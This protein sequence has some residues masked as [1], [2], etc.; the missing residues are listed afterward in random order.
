MNTPHE[1]MSCDCGHHGN[2][3]GGP[4]PTPSPPLANTSVP[5]TA[6]LQ[7]SD[8]VKAMNAKCKEMKM[9]WNGGNPPHAG[10]VGEFKREIKDLAANSF[11]TGAQWAHDILVAVE[12]ANSIE[13]LK[14]EVLYPQFESALNICLTEMIN[15]RRNDNG[16]KLFQEVARLK[17]EY[18]RK[19][20]GRINC[21]QLLWMIYDNCKYKAQG[22]S[23][24]NLNTVLAIRLGTSR[25][26]ECS[27]QQLRK[28]LFDWDR[29][30]LTI[31]TTVSDD[32]IY[33]CFYR[34]V[35]DIGFL[36][37]DIRNFDRLPEADRT[38]DRLYQLCRYNIENIETKHSQRDRFHNDTGHSRPNSPGMAVEVDQEGE[39]R[40]AVPG[41]TSGTRRKSRTPSRGRSKERGSRHKSSSRSHH[42]LRTRSLPKSVGS[43]RRRFRSR[44]A[45]NREL[46]TDYM[47]TRRCRF[48]TGSSFCKK[49][50]H[51][52]RRSRVLRRPPSLRHWKTMRTPSPRTRADMT[53]AAGVC[54]NFLKSGTCDFGDKCKYAHGENDPRKKRGGGKPGAPATSGHGSGNGNDRPAAPVTPS[55]DASKS[56]SKDAGGSATRRDSPCPDGLKE[57]F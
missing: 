54:F 55:D 6:G 39:Q 22:E 19:E 24:Y 4:N 1:G 51:P 56:N 49:S 14:V 8:M 52:R 30:M 57:N 42:R 47:M 36:E 32:V 17:A 31:T 25:P 35:S 37:F 28:F 50:H 23:V 21:L 3:G 45:G 5:A 10:N 29:L 38:Y 43:I 2:N 27:H 33:S 26:K 13:E 7:A 11:P 15:K 40:V 44:S 34:Q 46:C 53:A 12:K 48:N 16:E 18:E 9:T 41:T 20:W